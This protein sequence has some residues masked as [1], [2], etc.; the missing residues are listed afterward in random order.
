M[1]FPVSYVVGVKS[2][3]RIVF[4]DDFVACLAL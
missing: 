1:D 3:I 4:A 2:Y